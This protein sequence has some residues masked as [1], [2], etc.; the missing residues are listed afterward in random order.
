MAIIAVNIGLC[1]K[2]VGKSGKMVY[3]GRKIEIEKE[4]EIHESF[5]TV[6]E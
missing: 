6:E 1:N 3:N 4:Q 5:R 2:K